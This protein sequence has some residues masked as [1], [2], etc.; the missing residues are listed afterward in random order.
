[1][2][3]CQDGGVTDVDAVPE[4][5]PVRAVDDVD[6]LKVLADPTRLAILRELMT[7]SPRDM[8][9]LSVKELAERLDEPQTKLYRHVKQLLATGLILVAQ[10]RLVSGIVEQRYRTGQ[11]TLDLEPSLLGQSATT[12]DT[13]AMLTAS[14]DAFRE[15]MVSG[16]R[17][18]RIRFD[19]DAPPEE[20]YRRTIVANGLNR[21]P[22]AR[23]TEFRDRLSAL[24][25]EL[26]DTGWDDDGVT[27]NFLI[28]MY[29]PDEDRTESDSNG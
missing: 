20:S 6:T 21:V 22:A 10:T 8:P 15:E 18:G 29:A 17:T 28:V 13:T 26:V 1:M 3:A 9:V 16:L 25:H 7:G 24:V 23:A 27:V 12:G 19:A 4:P 14:L 5:L 2:N 11:L